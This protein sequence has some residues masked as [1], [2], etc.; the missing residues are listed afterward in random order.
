MIPHP[1]ALSFR[2]TRKK[3][4]YALALFLPELLGGFF[5]SFIFH[6]LTIWKQTAMHISVLPVLLGD[7]LS[8]HGRLST[9]VFFLF[10]SLLAS[11]T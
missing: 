11:H 2:G 8:S 1:F 5:T 9:P 4:F 3:G 7:I 6:A 10:S